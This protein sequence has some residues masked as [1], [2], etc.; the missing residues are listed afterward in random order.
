MLSEREAKIE[1]SRKY[2]KAC[3]LAKNADGSPYE[4]P[5]AAVV[6]F[7][8]GWDAAIEHVDKDVE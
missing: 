7:L 4:L 6:A 3:E 1:A 2:I 8:N 5:L